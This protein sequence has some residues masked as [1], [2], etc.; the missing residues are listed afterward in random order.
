MP[1]RTDLTKYHN[2]YKKKVIEEFNK[3]PE[4]FLVTKNEENKLLEKQKRVNSTWNKVKSIFNMEETISE[5]EKIQLKIINDPSLHKKILDI[6][7]EKINKNN[8][9]NNKN[10]KINGS[11]FN[12]KQ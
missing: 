2:A 4:K 8:I 12:N 11:I 10:Q 1:V 7:Q 5:K 9:Q 3:N 6:Q